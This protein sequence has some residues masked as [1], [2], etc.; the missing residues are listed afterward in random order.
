MHKHLD[1]LWCHFAS[2]G[3][4]I[5]LHSSLSASMCQSN[6]LNWCCHETSDLSDSLSQQYPHLQF[7]T[8]TLPGNSPSWTESSAIKETLWTWLRPILFSLDRAVL[9]GIQ[10]PASRLSC[11]SG[12]PFLLSSL[13]AA[14]LHAPWRVFCFV[15]VLSWKHDQYQTFVSDFLGY[16]LKV[17]YWYNAEKGG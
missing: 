13:W 4:S 12:L 9:W 14:T 10:G 15:S 2:S 11:C 3:Q 1:M 17:D 5:S 7:D 8:S 16:S 6:S